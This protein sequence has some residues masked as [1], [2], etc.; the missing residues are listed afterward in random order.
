MSFLW[1]KSS[2]TQ[3]TRT[4]AALLL[5]FSNRPLKPMP[6]SRSS[7]FLDRTSNWDPIKKQGIL[8]V[9]PDSEGTPLQKRG[10]SNRL[11]SSRLD[12]NRIARAWAVEG[13][14][15]NLAAPLQAVAHIGHHLKRS[16]RSLFSIARN[17]TPSGE[18]F[19]KLTMSGMSDTFLWWRN[20][21]H[22]EPGSP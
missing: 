20:T 19:K 14:E 16:Q 21:K 8:P 10:R 9:A 2:L 13:I 4:T 12:F 15:V 17:G 18:G 6:I 5:V 3:E 11:P 1:T 7:T 22:R